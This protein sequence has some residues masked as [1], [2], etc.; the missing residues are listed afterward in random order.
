MI[1]RRGDWKF[2]DIT[3]EAVLRAMRAVPRHEFVPDDLIENAYD[4]RPLPIGHGQTI[5]QPYMVAYMAAALQP[6]P[7]HRILEIG[8]GSGYH[9]AVL[10]EI[11]SCIYTIEIEEELARYARDRLQRLGYRNIHV[12]HGDGYEGWIEEAPFDSIL[13]TCAAENVPTPLMEQLKCGGRMVIPIG[14]PFSPQ[15]LILIE[16]Q[17][18][19]V[20]T[21]TLMPVRFVPFRR[22]IV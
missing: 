4:D 13:V 14:P 22:I 5:S 2:E 12:R 16:K 19:E 3:D 6:K 11:V 15:E 9:A 8:A 10:A 20:Y 17:G 18:L 21:H 1:D 7:P